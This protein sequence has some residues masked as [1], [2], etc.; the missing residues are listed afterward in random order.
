MRLAAL[1]VFH[2]IFNCESPSMIEFNQPWI[3]GLGIALGLGSIG[4]YLWY[5]ALTIVTGCQAEEQGRAF[6]ASGPLTG[7]VER[8]FFTVAIGL[9]LSG[10]ATAMLIWVTVKL[11]AHYHI[12]TSG[13]V[14]DLPRIYRALLSSLGSLIFVVWG[15]WVWQTGWTF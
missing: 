14:K 4:S 10:V 11:Q 15:G 7:I 2:E 1:V 8:L 9:G 5:K 13:N 6:F 3:L 12:F